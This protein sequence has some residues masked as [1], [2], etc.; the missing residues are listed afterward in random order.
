MSILSFT[1]FYYLLASSVAFEML[2][3]I[4]ILDA[5]D[6]EA[7]VGSFFCPQYSEIS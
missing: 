5:L 7:F 3:A 6:V 2:G 4:I 1:R